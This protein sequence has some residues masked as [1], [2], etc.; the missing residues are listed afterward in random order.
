MT[1][2]KKRSAWIESNCPLLWSL[3]NTK[4][5]RTLPGGLVE[6]IAVAS[7]SLIELGRNNLVSLDWH[8]KKLNT[9]CGWKTVSDNYRRDLSGVHS[10]DRVDELYFEIALCASVGR[11]SGKLKLHPPTGK[12]TYSDCCFYVNSFEI[13]GEVKRYLDPFP[14]IEKPGEVLSQKA[15]YTRSIAK[16]AMDLGSKLRD[17]HKQFPEGTLNILFVFNCSLAE[18][19]QDL[20]QALFGKANFFNNE[21]KFILK[22]DGLFY[23]DEWRNISACSL[24]SLNPEIGVIFPFMWKN[25]RAESK[26]P[27]PV[28]EAL[29]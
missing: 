24:A 2:Q 26:I 19:R 22:P 17:V 29:S 13:Y 28:L 14:H 7:P 16:R 6:Y 5:Q 25:P 21:A 27:M 1:D 23:L 12:G 3:L 11:F 8:L 9:L 15:P 4:A 10:A 20:T 18:L